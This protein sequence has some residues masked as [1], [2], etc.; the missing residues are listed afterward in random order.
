VTKRNGWSAKLNR[1]LTD[2]SS[3]ARRCVGKSAFK[4]KNSYAI[5]HVE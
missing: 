1:S 2:V 5:R 3:V 4:K